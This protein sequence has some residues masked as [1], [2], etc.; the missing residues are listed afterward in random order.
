MGCYKCEDA[1]TKANKVAFYRIGNEKIGWGNIALVGCP[2][3]IKLTLEIL[4][5]HKSWEKTH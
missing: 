5:L 3:H 2:D 4:N 1:V